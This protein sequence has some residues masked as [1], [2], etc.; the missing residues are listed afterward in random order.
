M[1]FQAWGGKGGQERPVVHIGV[2]DI[3]NSKLG[4]MNAAIT[5]S[6]SMTAARLQ[7]NKNNEWV[8]IVGDS[9]EKNCISM[10]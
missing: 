2:G 1:L 3:L 8:S 5:A 6:K 10:L 4:W 7:L 9:S